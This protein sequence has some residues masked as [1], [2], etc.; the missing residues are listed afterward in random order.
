VRSIN[1]VTVKLRIFNDG[2]LS[3][4][5]VTLCEVIELRH[6]ILET[7]E[8]VLESDDGYKEGDIAYGPMEAARTVPLAADMTSNAQTL[9]ANIAPGGSMACEF[10]FRAPPDH[11]RSLTLK[12][13]R[14]N[15][16]PAEV[17]IPGVP[18]V[19]IDDFTIAVHT[20]KP[21]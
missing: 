19:V 4:T 15:T 10:E 6:G 21:G 13:T 18:I 12:H 5:L 3:I 7:D 11:A 8:Y 17:A 20:P 16:L 14:R 9:Q 2:P 1:G